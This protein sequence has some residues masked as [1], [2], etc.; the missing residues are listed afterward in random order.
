MIS[1]LDR[2]VV[3]W[4]WTQ[5]FIGVRILRFRER[6]EEKD[7]EN[8]KNEAENGD[9]NQAENAQDEKQD[10]QEKDRDSGKG[11]TLEKVIEEPEEPNLKKWENYFK[12]TSKKRLRYLNILIGRRH[13]ISNIKQGVRKI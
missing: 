5:S 9:T 8:K 13:T 7:D 2:F 4:K 10:Q 6:E 12:N 11:D 3:A 1:L